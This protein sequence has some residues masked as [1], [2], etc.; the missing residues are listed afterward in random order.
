MEKLRFK[1]KEKFIEKLKKIPV[2]VMVSI[3]MVVM[4]LLI[5]VGYSAFNTT[6]NIGDIKAVVR[7]EKDVRVTG[8]SVD[9]STTG[10]SFSED[11]NVNNIS[12][13]V[14]L[15]QN[16][17]TV[18]YNVEITNIGTMEVGIFQVLEENLPSELTYSISGYNLKDKICDSSNV[19]KCT[20]GAKKTFKVTIKYRAGASASNTIY[21]FTLK[22]DFRNFHKVEYQDFKNSTDSYLKEVMDGEDYDYTFTENPPKRIKVTMI[23]SDVTDFDYNN[24]RLIIHNVTGDLVIT[25]IIPFAVDSWETIAENT[26]SSD[27][28]V[29]DER[30]ITF[31]VGGEQKTFTLRLAN[32][33]TPKECENQTEFSQTACGFVVEFKD[34]ISK[35]QMNSTDTNKGGWPASEMKKYLDEEIYPKLP[36]ELQDVIIDTYSI[37]GYGKGD[38]NGTGPEGNY[39]SNDKLYLLAPHEIWANVASS[40]PI[41]AD[42]GWKYTRQL[43]YYNSQKTTL[44][45]KSPAIKKYKGIAAVWWLSPAPSNYA[46]FFY[47]T[48]SN[49]TPYY[50]YAYRNYGVAPAF[51]IGLKPKPKSFATDDW[52]TI[53]ENTD[54]EVYK[55]GDERPITLEVD[56]EEKTFTLRLANKSTPS[57]CNDKTNFSQTACGFV[58]EFKDIISRHQMNITGTSKGGWPASEMKRYLDEEIYPKLPQELQDVIIDT[59]SIAGYGKGDANGTGPEGNWTTTNKLYLLAPHEVWSDNPSKDTAYNYTRQLD[60]YESQNTTNTHSI[61]AIKKYNGSTEYWWLSGARSI[62]TS[63]FNFVTNGG[64]WFSDSARNDRGV[65]PAFRIG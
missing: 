23:E 4:T 55:V 37:T 50:Y 43:D 52:K 14:S 54:S 56:G 45:N 63:D 30:K 60:Y 57:Q 53:A 18:T 16:T 21:P 40:V 9:S 6:V 65:A 39:I 24:N 48:D 32:K 10:T 15:P 27:Y 58:V 41:K 42:T 28:E 31:E 61:P 36:Q 5:S 47:H 8:I 19:S 51:R 3:I 17:S 1:R 11:Y 29:G 38:A 34:I 22:F 13:S 35:H 46:D 2:S 64:V 49:G 25:R 33:S 12:G 44:E 7:L 20:M 59:Y 62:Y 26:N